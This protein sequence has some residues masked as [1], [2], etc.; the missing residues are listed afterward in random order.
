MKGWW[1]GDRTSKWLSYH[2][3]V[4]VI[5][6]EIFKGIANCGQAQ[7]D[8]VLKEVPDEAADCPQAVRVVAECLGNDVH[9]E[10]YLTVIRS[11]ALVDIHAG[12]LKITCGGEMARLLRL[13]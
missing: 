11:I 5:S 12:G 3:A 7:I 1:R 9:F 10:C 4:R 6:L 8:C 13:G 2:G